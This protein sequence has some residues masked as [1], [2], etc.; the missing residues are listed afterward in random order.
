VV[1]SDLR[2][3]NFAVANPRRCVQVVIIICTV[4]GLGAYSNRDINR[5]CD[6]NPIILLVIK[7]SAAGKPIEISARPSI[8]IKIPVIRYFV[9]RPA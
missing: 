2:S 3:H 7:L 4:P 5:V 9:Y 8:G 1:I 6:I